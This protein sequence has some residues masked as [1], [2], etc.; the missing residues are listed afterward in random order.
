LGDRFWNGDIEAAYAYEL[1]PC[2]VTVEE[3]K[4]NPGGIS[5]PTEPTY[6]KYAR[7][8]QQGSPRGFA[9]PSK[10]VELYSHKFAAFGYPAMPEYIEPA[11]SPLSK[12]ELA[13]EFPLV[14]T[15]AKFTTYVHSQQRALPSLPKV[16]PEPSAELHPETAARYGIK[17]KQWMVVESPRGAITVRARV[18]PNILPGVVCCQHGWWQACR[19]LGLPGYDPYGARGANPAALIG[20]DLSDPISGSLPHRSYLCRIT[21]G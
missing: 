17:T 9:T 21:P 19:A 11:I 4:K 10:R 2:G 20:T 16:S 15:N 6:E 7:P 14:L 18:T 8:N 5:R 12:P 1:A 3:L 13:A